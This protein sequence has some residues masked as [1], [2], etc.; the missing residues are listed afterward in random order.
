MSITKTNGF[1]LACVVAMLLPVQAQQHVHSP[2]EMATKTA[3]LPKLSIPDVNV[4]DQDG[5]KQQ[6]YT[7]L[8]KDKTV[9]VNF[10]FTSCK[11]MC[12]L[13]G[14]N[15]S[16]LQSALGERLGQDV[17]LISVST[18]PETDSPEKMKA[19]GERFKAKNGWTFVT[20]NKEELAGLL[21][22]FTGD[23]LRKG[24]HAPSLCIV[25]DGKK[26]HRW[27]Y[28]FEAPER[29]IEMVDELAKAR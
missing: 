21:R 16:K 5:R 14:A 26:T 27:A 1:I 28:G 7:D 15:F 17:F 11:A 4:L 20:G 8:V 19:W 18:D 25:N 23:G 10:V 24:Y 13:L 9:V 12:P 6:F 29:V 3:T 22:V 2:P